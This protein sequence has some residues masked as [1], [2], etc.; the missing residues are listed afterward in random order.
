MKRSSLIL[1]AVI[2]VVVL[3]MFAITLF[4][5]MAGLSGGGSGSFGG[6]SRIAVIPVEGVINNA[7]AKNVN[8]YLKQYGED[9]RV[10]AIILRVDS[11]GGGVSDSQEIYRE[12]KRVKDE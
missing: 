12:V 1:I 4:A 10:K 5:L 2:S 8:R 11:P 6:G 9:D 7:T 3:G